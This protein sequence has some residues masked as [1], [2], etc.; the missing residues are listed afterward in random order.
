LKKARSDKNELDLTPNTRMKVMEK[1][2]KN[3]LKRVRQ[4]LLMHDQDAAVPK[5]LRNTYDGV[6]YFR[7]TNNCDARRKDLDAAFDENSAYVVDGY[8]IAWRERA[9]L[10][11]AARLAI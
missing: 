7:E 8:V 10:R 9:R 1:A 2:G 3:A 11:R 4:K 5:Q 6:L